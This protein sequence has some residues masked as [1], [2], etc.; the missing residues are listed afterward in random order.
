MKALAILVV[1]AAACES[2]EDPSCLVRV[3][4]TTIAGNTMTADGTFNDAQPLLFLTGPQTTVIPGETDEDGHATFDLSGLP[5]GHYD[6]HF[7]GSCYDA[8]DDPT[9]DADT[10][11]FTLP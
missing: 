4:S 8:D 7:G 1:L 5:A 3:N 2:G 11:S 9:V 10:G 6:Y